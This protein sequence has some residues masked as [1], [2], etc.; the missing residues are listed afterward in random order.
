VLAQQKLCWL[1]PC[2]SG[3][4]S[5]CHTVLCRELFADPPRV[6]VL[7]GDQ[8][9]QAFWKRVADEHADGFDIILDD[10]GD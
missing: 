5:Q 1:L 10:G 8:G 6:N 7:I 9:S 2:W 4:A 3:L